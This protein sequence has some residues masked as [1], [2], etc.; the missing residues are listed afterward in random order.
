M[1]AKITQ[2]RIFFLKRE[3]FRS[4]QVG[5]AE[6]LLHGTYPYCPYIGVHPPPASSLPP[7]SLFLVS[8]AKE[9]IFKYFVRS[10]LILRPF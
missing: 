6:G 9:V 5:K 2:K 3:S 1:K 4:A 8:H 7:L 10:M